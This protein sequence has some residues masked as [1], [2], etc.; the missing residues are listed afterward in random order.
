MRGLI[1][2]LLAAG[3]ALAQEIVFPYGAVYFRKSNPPPAD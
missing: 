1:G 3:C 2:M